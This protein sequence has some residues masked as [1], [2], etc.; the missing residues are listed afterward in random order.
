MVTRYEDELLLAGA[1][2]GLTVEF[3]P[4]SSDPVRIYEAKARLLEAFKHFDRLVIGALDRDVEVQMVLQDIEAGS[5]TTWV[6]NKLRAVDDTA[7][8]E[9]DWKQQ[10]GTYAVKAKYL[11]VDYLNARIEKE[12]TKRLE[13]LREDLF[14]LALESGIRQLPLPD[15][16]PMKE[17]IRPLDEIQ[18]AKRIMPRDT[19]LRIRS[20]EGT[21][22]IDINATKTPSDYIGLLEEQLS[23]GEMEMTLLVRKPDYLGDTTWEFRHGNNRVLAHVLDD[24]WLDRF[25]RGE[26]VIV[27]GS[28]LVCTVSYEYVYSH[29]GSLASSRHDVTRVHRAIGPAAPQI[30][31]DDF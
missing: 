3:E 21:K 22:S 10:V 18:D 19:S 30:A 2:F 24:A 12:E 6:R 5:I 17:L 23:H 16:I 13:N 4:G 15:H 8:K 31:F 14:K 25:R 29:D 9:F 7:L 28:A 26:E 27:P 1:D 20:E 11:A